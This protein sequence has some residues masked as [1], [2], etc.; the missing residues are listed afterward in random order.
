MSWWG[1][2]VGGALGFALVEPIGALLSA[3]LGHT[4]DRDIKDLEARP[5]ILNLDK[6]EDTQAAFF[7]A[8]FSAMGHFAKPTVE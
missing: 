5:D 8:T 6:N 3:A 7:T 2:L 4:I 1:K